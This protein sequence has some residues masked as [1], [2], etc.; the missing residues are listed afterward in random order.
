M[1]LNSLTRRLAN[2][3]S[4]Y[5]Q[6]PYIQAQNFFKRS[7]KKTL[8]PAQSMMKSEGS[9]KSSVIS[10]PLH[11]FKS[12][13]QN[14]LVGKSDNTSEARMFSSATAF[15]APHHEGTKHQKEMDI[16]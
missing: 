8:W 16:S 4:S 15:A 2:Q 5:C 12:N 6:F 10:M 11:Q 13:Y 7:S 9:S 1:M 3:H 14:T